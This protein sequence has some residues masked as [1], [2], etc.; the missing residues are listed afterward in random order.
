MARLDVEPGLAIVTLSRRNLLSLLSKLEWTGSHRMI[1]TE[2][3]YRFG[4]PVNDTI[5]VIQAEDDDD[6]YAKRPAPPGSM[7]P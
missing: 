3:C 4:E 6:H 2:H 1:M 7:H 5:L